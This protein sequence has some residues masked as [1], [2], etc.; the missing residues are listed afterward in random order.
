M[1]RLIDSK[2]N[3]RVSNIQ[4]MFRLKIRDTLSTKCCTFGVSKTMLLKFSLKYKRD[5]GRNMEKNDRKVTFCES[6]QTTKNQ[7]SMLIADRRSNNK[8]L[9]FNQN[10]S[11]NGSSKSCSRSSL[12]FFS[13]ICTAVYEL[14]VFPM[15]DSAEFY[16]KGA[17]FNRPSRILHPLSHGARLSE[18]L[19][20]IGWNDGNRK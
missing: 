8:C 18:L 15:L 12:D 10:S 9:T 6:K 16:N 17:E 20:L 7:T 3:I 1:G 19:F 11:L 2:R 13:S 4:E 14:S 5:G